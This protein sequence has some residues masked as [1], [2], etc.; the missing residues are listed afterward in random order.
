MPV[1][2]AFEKADGTTDRPVPS[3]LTDVQ[4]AFTRLS[5][6][7]IGIPRLNRDTLD[8]FVRRADLMQAYV[9][10]VMVK[11]DGAPLVF[12]RADFVA[13]LPEARTNWT[14]VGKR[15]F[16]A[17]MAKERDAYWKHLDSKSKD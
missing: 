6:M 7:G 10:P 2:Y 15:D 9:G 5:D 17:T 1:H 12:T 11:P 3:D 14:A 16:D 8:E 13:L 4:Y